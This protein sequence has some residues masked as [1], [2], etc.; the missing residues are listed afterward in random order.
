MQKTKNKINH[1][2]N[3][4]NKTTIKDIQLNENEIDEIINKNNYIPLKG[5]INKIKTKYIYLYSSKNYIYY[6]CN[7]IKHCREEEKWT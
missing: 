1:E 6:I 5:A 2:N 3:K 7:K 4:N